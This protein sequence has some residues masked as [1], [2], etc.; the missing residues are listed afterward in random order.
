MKEIKRNQIGRDVKLSPYSDDMILY[1]EN[2]NDSTQKLLKVINKII[3]TAVYNIRT[4][5]LAAFLYTNNEIL[6]KQLKKPSK[7]ITPKK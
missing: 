5:K 1:I 7:K 2:L 6:E 4:Q 3:L